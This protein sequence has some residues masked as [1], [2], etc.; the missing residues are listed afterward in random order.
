M[1][2]KRNRHHLRPRSRGGDSH[3]SNLLLIQVE[4]HETWHRL[5]GN[6]TL[7]EVIQLLKRVE[8]AKTHQRYH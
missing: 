1:F 7:S 5:F 4:R 2:R 6:R 3:P 8:R